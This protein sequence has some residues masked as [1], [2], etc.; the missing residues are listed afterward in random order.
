MSAVPWQREVKPLWDFLPS[1]DFNLVFSPTL[2]STQKYFWQK[3]SIDPILSISKSPSRPENFFFYQL[4]KFLSQVKAG[5]WIA[6]GQKFSTGS[7]KFSI[8]AQMQGFDKFWNYFQPPHTTDVNGKLHL[9]QL[10]AV[11]WILSIMCGF[12]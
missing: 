6:D 11:H 5:C 3:S 12:K 4:M 8:K 9:C 10:Q 1:R 7:D 2:A